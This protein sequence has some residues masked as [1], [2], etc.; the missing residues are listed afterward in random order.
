MSGGV[1]GG[2]HRGGGIGGGCVGVGVDVGAGVDFDVTAVEVF[3][4][5]QLLMLKS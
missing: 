5:E 2:G 1:G 4:V 3:R